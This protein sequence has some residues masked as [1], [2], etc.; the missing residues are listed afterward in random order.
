[1]NLAKNIRQAR[2]NSK[3][4]QKELANKITELA[5][6]NG[7]DDLKFGDT[8]ISNWERG[9]SKPDADTIFLLCKALNVDANY[10]LDWDEVVAADSLQK[11]LEKVLREN[12]FFEGEDLTEENLD[13]LVKFMIKNKEFLVKK[14]D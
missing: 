4:S 8:A 12:S 10:L 5:K 2:I 3:L 9:T 1:M 14:K 6:K 7:Y 13:M 11:S